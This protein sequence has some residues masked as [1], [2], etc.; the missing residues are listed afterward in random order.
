MTQHGV[1]PQ[2]VAE[3]MGVGRKRVE[4]KEGV[5]VCLRRN[6]CSIAVGLGTWKTGCACHTH[7][8]HHA[9]HILSRLPPGGSTTVPFSKGGTPYTSRR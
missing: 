2:H 1:V 4:K 7:P 6:S 5:C 9:T 3:G 8:A